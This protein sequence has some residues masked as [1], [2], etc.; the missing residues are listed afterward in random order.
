MGPVT[1]TG[2]HMQT[3]TTPKARRGSSINPQPLDAALIPD[4]LLKQ[5]TVSAIVGLSSASIYRKIAAGDFPAPVRLGTR[6]TRWRAGDVTAWLARQAAG[7][8]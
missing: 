8:A 1:F 4:S 6:C 2:A 5:P 3:T 7:A